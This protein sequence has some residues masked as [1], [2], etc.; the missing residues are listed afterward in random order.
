MKRLSIIIVGLLLA[1]LAACGGTP[2]ISNEQFIEG[3]WQYSDD[4]DGVQIYVE[5]E[6]KAG[7]FTLYSVTQ[8][9]KRQRGK[10]RIS[11]SDGNTIV[12]ELYD[13]SGDFATDDPYV[14]ITIDHAND[15]L[16]ILTLGPFERSPLPSN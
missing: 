2:S 13:Q 3:R 11:R 4:S 16:H 9:P 7:A 1:N 6:F 15:T 8:P 14:P 10:Y 12:L 5:W